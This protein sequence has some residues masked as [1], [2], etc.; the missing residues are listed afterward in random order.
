MIR[1]TGEFFSCF[2]FEGTDFT[3]FRLYAR[4]PAAK[5]SKLRK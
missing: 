3:V 4:N 2:L 5:L 1:L